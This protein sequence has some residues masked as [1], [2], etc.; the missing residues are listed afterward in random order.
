MIRKTGTFALL[1][2]GLL[3]LASCGNNAG[4]MASAV[5]VSAVEVRAEAAETDDKDPA[6]GTDDAS[7]QDSTGSRAQAGESGGETDSGDFRE[8]TSGAGEENG[9]PEEDGSGAGEEN[10]EPEEDGSGTEENGPGDMNGREEG[11]V[12]ITV[13]A[14]GDVT[15]GNYL[16]Q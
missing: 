11:E 13:S 15:M 3:L 1:L 2:A 6:G 4:T 10:G 14:A 9:E 16:G 8:T 5:E 12:R 7:G